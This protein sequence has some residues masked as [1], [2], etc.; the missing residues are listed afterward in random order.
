MHF[1]PKILSFLCN[2][3]AYAGADLAGISPFQIRQTHGSFE[4]CAPAGSIRSSSRKL[5]L[6]GLTVL[7]CSDAIP[8][9]AI[10]SPGI[11]RRRKRFILPEN[12]LKWPKSDLRGSFSIG[13]Q[14][15]KVNALPKWCVNSL[16]RSG[17]LDPSASIRRSERSFSPSGT[18]L[19]GKRYD[20]WWA[21]A[22][23]LEKIMSMESGSGKGRIEGVIEGTI[24]DEFI[25]NRIM[26]LV[27]SRPLPASEI[28]DTLKVKMKETLSYLVS[29]IG[30]GRIG[31]DPSEEGK[32]PKYI[33]A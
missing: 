32:V 29:L 16:R 23:L 18:L 31:F 10:I 25:K 11:S 4:S 12:S 22:Q 5:F 27:E 7:S 20:G 1:E 33:K 21:K 14:Q 9:T 8:E 19:T 17:I 28:S 3:C 30:E 15:G 2:W 13:S 24:R 26:F 6:P